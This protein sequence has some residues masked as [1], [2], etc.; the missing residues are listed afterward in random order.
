[1][2][3]VNERKEV[4]MNTSQAARAVLNTSGMSARA[5]SSALGKSQNYISSLI[6]QAE[7]MNADMGASTV[8][9]IGDVCGYALVLVP[10][11]ELKSLESAVMIDP[12]KRNRRERD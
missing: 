7:R 4:C 6:S 3:T 8:A 10:R 12:A 5:V 2:R 11:E 1:M 9:S